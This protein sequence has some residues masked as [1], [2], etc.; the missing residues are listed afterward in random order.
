MPDMSAL[1]LNDNS[2]HNSI[3]NDS[4]H[5]NLDDFLGVKKNEGPSGLLQRQNTNTISNNASN[6]IIVNLD[7]SGL[8][9]QK[10]G[11][12]FRTS[13]F[14]NQP[15][16]FPVSPLI[17]QNQFVL[18]SAENSDSAAHL[19]KVVLKFVE[20]KGTFD[21]E[22]LGEFLRDLIALVDRTESSINLAKLS[23]LMKEK[24]KILEDKKLRILALSFFKRR[25]NGTTEGRN[26]RNRGKRTPVGSGA[27]VDPA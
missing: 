13:S 17:K 4:A 6:N 1:N 23:S 22:D 26:Q 20:D 11:S 15:L 25:E 5:F 27:R 10:S 3:L 14:Q 19:L 9:D 21:S 12:N 18:Q 7:N 8:N 2:M 24:A 16:Q